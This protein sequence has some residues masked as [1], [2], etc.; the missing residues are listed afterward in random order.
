MGKRHQPRTSLA[1][2]VRMR[3]ENAGE[4]RILTVCTLD[5]SP[6]GCRLWTDALRP[7]QIVELQYGATRSRFRVVWTDGQQAGLASLDGKQLFRHLQKVLG[8]E[9]RYRMGKPLW[10]A[11]TP[12][13]SASPGSQE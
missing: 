3:I 1:A 11:S 9:D 6:A 7:G 5:A 10:Q 8:H 12:R 2:P 4:V 13:L